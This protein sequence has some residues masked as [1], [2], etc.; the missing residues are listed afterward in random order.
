MKCH[1]H[2]PL[3]YSQQTEGAPLAGVLLSQLRVLITTEP[4]TSRVI[5]I[6]KCS[7]MNRA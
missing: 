7:A 5:T 1:R 4:K 3:E 6:Y 2:L